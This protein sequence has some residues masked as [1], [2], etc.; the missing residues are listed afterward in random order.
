MD[1]IKVKE[2]ALDTIIHKKYVLDNGLLIAGYFIDNGDLNSA[3][4]I[5]RRVASHDNSKFDDD[6]FMRLA[7][8][9]DS[10][11][12]FTDANAQLSE[13]KRDAIK[14]HWKC[15]RHHPEYF[16]DKSEMTEMDMIE[17]VCDW[18]ARSLQYK[19]DFIDFVLERQ[20][21]RFKFEESQ[22]TYILEWCYR[23]EVLYNKQKSLG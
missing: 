19:T 4:E 12:C 7:S 3:I 18:F 23:L 15:N 8:I 22:F 11:E 17:M 16:Q 10:R 2:M 20:R 5:L 13:I 21:N 9:L 6:E 1:N 14:Y